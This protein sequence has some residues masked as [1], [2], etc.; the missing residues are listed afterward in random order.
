MKRAAPMET[1]ALAS[2]QKTI[3]GTKSSEMLMKQ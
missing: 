1:H 2:I 3:G